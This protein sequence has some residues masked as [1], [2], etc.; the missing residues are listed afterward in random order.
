MCV[1]APSKRQ[2]GRRERVKLFLFLRDNDNDV[3]HATKL[4]PVHAA[5]N[6]L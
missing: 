5:T 3:L 4:G 1:R 6:C 2:P